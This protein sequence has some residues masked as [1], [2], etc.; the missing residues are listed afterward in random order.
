MHTLPAVTLLLLA[1]LAP[2]PPRPATP[3]SDPAAV[4]AVIDKVVLLPDERAPS[5]VEL[6]GAFAIAEGDRG[7]YYRAPRA[8]VLRFAV[9]ED[10]D[11]SRQQWRDLQRRAGTNV[12][13]SFGSRHQLRAQGLRA[14]RVVAPDDPA[15][16]ATPP[17]Y[18]TGWGVHGLENVD[19][20][21]AR[22]LAL[23]PRCL[24]I[25]LGSEKRP[26]T[27][28]Q[29]PVV[30][31]CTNCVASGADHYVFTVETSDGERHGSGLVGPGKGITTWTTDLALQT[32]ERITWH[33]HVVGAAI[34][35]A[36]IATGTF[37]VPAS[38]MERDG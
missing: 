13:V 29:R 10:A 15:D 19:Y 34:E 24:P 6:H 7:Q 16:A 4:Y 33:V 30:L 18:S 22:E 32:G 14:L 12:A 27:S 31:S 35:R 11:A 2:L 17:A 9:G 8:G 26:A 3:P 25:D 28:P 23:L 36:P 1:P 5:S 21:P 38:A 37:V 20:G